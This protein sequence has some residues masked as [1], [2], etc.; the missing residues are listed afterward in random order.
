MSDGAPGVTALAPGPGGGDPAD[1]GVRPP[2][3]RWGQEFVLICPDQHIA[4]RAGDAAE[5]N[6][7]VV[8]GT[9]APGGY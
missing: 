5:I 6:L 3:Y 1:R 2:G 8:T 7:D 9:A 4:W